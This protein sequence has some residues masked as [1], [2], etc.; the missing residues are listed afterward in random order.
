MTES[1]YGVLGRVSVEFNVELLAE[2]TL[3][4]GGTNPTLYT[5]QQ[6]ARVTYEPSRV[7]TQPWLRFQNSPYP[8]LLEG[9]LQLGIS[10]AWTVAVLAL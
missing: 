4:E 2:T 9:I 1:K 5:D 6:R 3:L 10:S 8:A 7:P